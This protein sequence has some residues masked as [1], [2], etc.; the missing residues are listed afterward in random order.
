MRRPVKGR[1]TRQTDFYA[2]VR[3]H[4]PP[5]LLIRTPRR[6]NHRSR[7]TFPRLRDA[8][9]LL[10]CLARCLPC[11]AELAVTWFADGSSRCAIPRGSDRATAHGER[12]G[13]A[14]VPVA[15]ASSARVE[16]APTAE[17][18]VAEVRHSRAGGP[19]GPGH[20]CLHH[21]Q[22]ERV[23]GRKTR[24]GHQRCVRSARSHAPQHQSGR[25]CPGSEGER[26]SV[27]SRRL[28]CKPSSQG[29]GHPAAR[30]DILRVLPRRASVRRVDRGSS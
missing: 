20:R 14:T 27:W 18:C 12:S 28:C 2:S 25:S 13:M 11:G 15:P 17:D 1:P 16:H 6:D 30:G 23:G 19:V 4:A 9:C 5:R 3:V 24:T 21:A 7:C 26:L 8:E 22:L 10:L 29:P